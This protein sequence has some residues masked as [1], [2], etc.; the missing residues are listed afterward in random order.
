MWS[1]PSGKGRLS[2]LEAELLASLL[3]ILDQLEL[4]NLIASGLDL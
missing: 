4:S 1:G 2:R 3:Q